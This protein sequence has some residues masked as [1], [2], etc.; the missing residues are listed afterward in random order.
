MGF[1]WWSLS[2]RYLQFPFDFQYIYKLDNQYRR[3]GTAL[4]IFC[5]FNPWDIPSAVPS[6]YLGYW[7]FL[8]HSDVLSDQEQE[9]KQDTELDFLSLDWTKQAI[10]TQQNTFLLPTNLF[11]NEPFDEGQSKYQSL[12]FNNPPS[13]PLRLSNF[14]AVISL[15][16]W[17]IQSLP[18]IYETLSKFYKY[19]EILYQSLLHWN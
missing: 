2:W 15:C 8:T 5:G 16:Y 12:T 19:Y 6:I 3:K 13:T 11:E 10:V 1:L 18:E 14:T 17:P 4:G 7:N 9:T